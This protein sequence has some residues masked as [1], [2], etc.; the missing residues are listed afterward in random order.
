M[1]AA[2]AAAYPI[3]RDTFAQ[4]DEILGFRLSALCFS[5]P[6][7]ELT[8]TRNAQPAILT[9]SI[10]ALRALQAERPGLAAPCFVA[11]HSLGEYSALVAARRWNRT[12]SAETRAGI[13]GASRRVASAAW[14]LSCD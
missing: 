10:A 1:V 4:A 9:A 7:E 5:G 12:L 8:D 13:D 11:G 6:I 14:P 2:L 3:A